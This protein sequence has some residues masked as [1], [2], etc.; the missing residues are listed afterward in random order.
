MLTGKSVER[1]GTGYNNMDCIDKNFEF[2]S[3]L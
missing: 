1:T 2:C 3:I